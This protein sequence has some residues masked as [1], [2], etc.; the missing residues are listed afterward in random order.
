MM[1]NKVKLEV[2]VDRGD[3]KDEISFAFSPAGGW[4]EMDATEFLTVM[5]SILTWIAYAMILYQKED[6]DDDISIE[7]YWKF[8]M[9]R[10]SAFEE[11]LNHDSEEDKLN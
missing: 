8:F 9:E 6:F 7:D 2:N 5:D 10:A 3:G 11:C 4:E 1:A